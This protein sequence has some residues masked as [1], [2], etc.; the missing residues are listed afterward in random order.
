M[1]LQLVLVE[2][3]GPLNVGSVARLCANFGVAGLRLV[4]PRCDPE[5]PDA[6]R[7]A[8]AGRPLLLAAERYPHLAAALADRSRV[9]ACSGRGAGEPL[10]PLPPEQALPWLLQG[11]GATALVFGREDRGL[12]TDELL[13]A[14]RILAIPTPPGYASLNLSHA[15]AI[16][17][18]GLHSLAGSAVAATALPGPGAVATG[19]GEPCPRGDLEAALAA[20]ESLLL[21]V[22]FLF[23]HTA[24]AR[25][26]KLRALLQRAQP[27]GDEVALLRGMVAQLRWASRHP[28]PGQIDPGP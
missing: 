20:A 12:S 26:R 3:A 22:G 2:P 27:N 25:M 28:R 7:M 19:E 6:L 1:D 11:L 10:P 23:P 21:E 18:H 8:M 5:D 17:L 14:D 4:A 9:V 15:V 24:R 13:Q 16:V